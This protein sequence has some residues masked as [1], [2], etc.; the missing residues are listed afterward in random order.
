MYGNSE[1]NTHFD[2]VLTFN[3][4]NLKLQGI[5]TGLG[6]QLHNSLQVILTV[7]RLFACDTNI[8]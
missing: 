1:E 4:V 2:I 8:L 5:L 6:T 7:A 3:T